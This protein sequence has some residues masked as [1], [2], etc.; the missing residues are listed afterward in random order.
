MKYSDVLYASD[1]KFADIMLCSVNSLL[2]N[3]GL[4]NIRLHIVCENFDG[5]NYKRLEKFVGQYPQTELYLYPIEDFGVSIPEWKGGQANNARLFYPLKIAER[6]GD[7]E[8]LLY[9]DSD[10]IICGDLSGLADYRDDILC[11]CPDT[12]IFDSAKRIQSDIYFNAGV[13]YINMNK[14][15]NE[16][17]TG[18]IKRF[19]SCSDRFSLLCP[20]QDTLN[21]VLKGRIRRLPLR[22]NLN[23]ESAFFK[24]ICAKLYCLRGPVSYP[25]MKEAAAAPL[26]CHTYGGNDVKPWHENRINPF[27]K[28]FRENM[29]DVNPDFRC[30]PLSGHLAFL[31]NHPSIYASYRLL[32]KYMPDELF[33]QA[34]R[35]IKK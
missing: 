21:T 9:L 30:L 5:D 16:D 8:N 20:D 26:I 33:K 23:F 24:G 22:Y 18:K 34:F 27:N 17:I 29:A 12:G 4:P 14:W 13:L 19:L 6:L 25:E 32:R 31:A 7:T 11:A 1:S 10:T 28:I 15:L 35:L 2:K 3:G